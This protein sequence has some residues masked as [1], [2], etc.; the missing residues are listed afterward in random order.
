MNSETAALWV[1]MTFT[2]F[3]LQRPYSFY[4]SSVVGRL[5]PGMT[6]AKAQSEADMMAQ[7]M[8]RAVPQI[9]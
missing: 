1:P 6:L 3:E 7:Q 5:K 2:P 9:R 4:D 8:L